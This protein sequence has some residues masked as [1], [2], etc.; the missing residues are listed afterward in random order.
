MN[1]T[2][3][4]NLTEEDIDIIHRMDNDNDCIVR[5]TSLEGNE[6]IWTPEQATQLKAQLLE[7]HE[8]MNEFDQSWKDIGKYMCDNKISRGKLIAEN[9]LLHDE[10]KELKKQILME[11]IPQ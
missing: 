11:K 4:I 8:I 7:D 9:L 3:R 10:I 2:N 6:I 5:F 1:L